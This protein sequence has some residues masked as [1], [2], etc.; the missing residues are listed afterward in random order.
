[1]IGDERVSDGPEQDGVEHAE[2]CD[3]VIGHQLPVLAEIIRP[4]GKL[5]H[6]ELEATVATLKL[7]ENLEAGSHDLL[8]DAVAGYDGD[9]V[10]SH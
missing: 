5:L 6:V 1:M 7:H 3:A 2:S 9:A 8:S 10:S 4:P